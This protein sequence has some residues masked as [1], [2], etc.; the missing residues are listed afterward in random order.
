MPKS[1]NDIHIIILLNHIPGIHS[2][3]SFVFFLKYL[4]L[5]I[6]KW[7]I[8][9]LL[10]IWIIPFACFRLGFQE[11]GWTKITKISVKEP[12]F[13]QSLASKVMNVERGFARRMAGHARGIILGMESP[14]HSKDGSNV[15][16]LVFMEES[17]SA[18]WNLLRFKG[19][20][21]FV[22][23]MWKTRLVFP[24]LLLWCRCSGV[25]QD[26]GNQELKYYQRQQEH[27]SNQLGGA[28]SG[29][30]IATIDSSSSLCSWA[31]LFP[32]SGTKTGGE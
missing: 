13:P 23:S 7:Y 32:P 11:K 29:A 18:D 16:S 17:G 9:G 3:Q 2:L 15:Y 21:N 4:P 1:I 12:L 22:G 14:Y 27:H 26:F 25:H 6:W 30:M 8:H 20:V 10:P 5:F 31:V 28:S 24:N 19:T